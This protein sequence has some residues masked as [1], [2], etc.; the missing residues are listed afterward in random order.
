MKEADIKTAENYLFTRT[1]VEHRKNMEGT[2]VTVIGKKRGT[3]KANYQGGILT[4]VG[5][6]T[7]KFK[8]SNGQYANAANLKKIY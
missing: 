6:G 1:D 5:K 2:I 7:L 3:K 8:L 4:G